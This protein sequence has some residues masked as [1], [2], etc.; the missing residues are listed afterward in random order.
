M[1]PYLG[2]FSYNTNDWEFPTQVIVIAS[3]FHSYV[4]AATG[5]VQLQ[6]AGPL[7]D[8]WN[9]S[10][11]DNFQYSETCFVDNTIVCQQ[12]PTMKADGW[13]YLILFTPPLLS[14][15]A[16]FASIC[17]YRTPICRRF[18]LVSVLAGVERDSLYVLVGATFSGELEKPIRLFVDPIEKS[19]SSP[20]VF[21]SVDKKEKNGG[22]FRKTKYS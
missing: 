6:Q 3:T 15:L 1:S 5:F 16:F 4:A 18:G 13:L 8:M 19:F 22:I 10:G 9:P 7:W 21:Y 11:T 14:V 12:V 17:L 20:Q 2:R